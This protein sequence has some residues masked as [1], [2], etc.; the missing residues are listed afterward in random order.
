VTV[1]RALVDRVELVDLVDLVDL[2][3]Q[4]PVPLI[5]LFD[6]PFGPRFR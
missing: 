2:I 1:H 3:I 4:R 6:G 5:Y